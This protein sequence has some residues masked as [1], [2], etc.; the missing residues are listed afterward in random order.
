MAFF[1]TESD[2]GEP[3]AVRLDL[4]QQVVHRYVDYSL[5]QQERSLRGEDQ[6]IA[7]YRLFP[8]IHRWCLFFIA[9][10]RLRFFLCEKLYLPDGSNRATSKTRS[11]DSAGRRSLCRL[12]LFKVTDLGISRK[13]V[14]DFLLVNNTNLLPISHSLPDIAQYWSNCRF[15]QGTAVPLSNKFVLRNLWNYRHKSHVAKTRFFGLQFVGYIMGMW[16]LHPY[17]YPIPLKRRYQFWHV[18]SCAGLINHAKF[19]LDRFRGFGAPGGRKSLSSIEWRYRPY[20]SV[21]TNV[22]RCDV[23]F[24]FDVICPKSCRIRWNNAK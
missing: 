21:H 14:C 10:A 24:H 6:E 4:Q 13:S 16:Q 8:R 5:S 20:N 1:F 22:L 23:F 19:Q 17:P 7:A 9:V 3:Q 11:R 15:W 2:A 12:R 18:R